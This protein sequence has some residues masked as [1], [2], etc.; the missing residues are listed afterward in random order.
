MNKLSEKIKFMIEDISREWPD[1]EVP[2]RIATELWQEIERLRGALLDIYE[3]SLADAGL[4]D[5]DIMNDTS[6][7]GN[8]KFTLTTS[9]ERF[10]ESKKG[11]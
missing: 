1:D 5:E 9:I 4:S 7:F 2:E 11:E 10:G 8:A 3:C 6:A